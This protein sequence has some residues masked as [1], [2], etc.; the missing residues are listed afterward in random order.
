V[1]LYFDRQQQT[2]KARLL[3]WLGL[4]RPTRRWQLRCFWELTENERTQIDTHS[5]IRHSVLFAH[6]QWGIDL[7]PTVEAFTKPHD[8]AKAR[9]FIVY[10]IDRLEYLE[11]Q[12]RSAAQETKRRLDKIAGVEGRPTITDE[13]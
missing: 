11:R 9:S 6:F 13:I 3:Q 7:S 12:I 1:K 2:E 5:E 4:E 10:D 8:L